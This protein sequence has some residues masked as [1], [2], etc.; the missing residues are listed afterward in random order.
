MTSPQNRPARLSGSDPIKAV[1][2]RVTEATVSVDGATVGAIGPGLLVLFCAER[3][4]T[5]DDADY[6]A[7]KIA[8]MR[9][10]ADTDGKTNLSVLDIN[11]SVLAVSQF[12][13]ATDWRKGNRPGFSKAGDHEAAKLLYEHFCAAL[14]TEGVPVETGIFAA[15]MAVTLSNDGPFTIVMDGR[16]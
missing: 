11:G 5:P 2:Q 14:H 3:D 13:L 4:D 8:K 9:L 1:L 16:D 6:F 12:T 10:F 7:R 15:D